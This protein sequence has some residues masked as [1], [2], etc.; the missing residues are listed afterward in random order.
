MQWK[1][2][3]RRSAPVC[4]R[5]TTLFAQVVTKNEDILSD[6]DTFKRLQGL[7]ER[8]AGRER[9]FFKYTWTVIHFSCPIV[10][11]TFVLR[12]RGGGGNILKILS[13]VRDVRTFEMTPKNYW[14]ISFDS[15]QN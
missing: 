11:H 3:L 12:R 1:L 13:F 9:R 10:N 15:N 5:L 6:G 8:L 2:S 7:R 4:V 14:T